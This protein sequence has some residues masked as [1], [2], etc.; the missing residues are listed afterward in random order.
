M[1]IVRGRQVSIMVLFAI[2]LH[3]WWTLM[4][5]VDQSALN[6]T[7][8][9]SLYR[10]IHPASL[11]AGVVGGAAVMAFVG[12]F[13][14]RY[15]WLIILLIPQQ[16]L[17]MMS[18]IGALDAMWLAQFADGVLRPRAFIAADQMYSVL[19]AIGHTMAIIARAMDRSNDGWR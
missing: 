1:L 15:P 12:L 14:R 5:L 3:L 9:S 8:L 18:A 16:A 10:Y 7:G 2:A 13:V 17:L 4:I 6:A 11:L 19:A